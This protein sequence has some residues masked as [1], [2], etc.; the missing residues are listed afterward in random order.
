MGEWH[1]D[2]EAL[3]KFL[4]D[5]LTDADSRALQRHLFRC[6]ACEGQLIRLLP[7]VPGH[8]RNAVPEDLEAGY[9]SLIRELMDEMR[10]EMGD[11]KALLAREHREAQGL[12]REIRDLTS[13]QR[14]RRVKDHPRFHTWGLFELLLE[15]SR[16][17]TRVEP[18]RAEEQ[19]RLAL[20]L[21]DRLDPRRYGPGSVEA[22]KA[23][24]W[25]YLGN[26]LRILSHFRRAEQAF[27]MAELYL[28]QSWHDPLDEALILDLKGSLRR[29]QRRFDESLVLLDDAIG[30]YRELN[31]PHLQGRALMT[32]GL[33]L[34]YNGDVAG[35]T[36]CFRS[37]LFLLDGTEEPRLVAASQFNLMTCLYDSGLTVEAAALIPEARHLMEQVGT[38]SDLLHLRWL[39]AAVAAVLGQNE[40]AEQAFIEVKDAFSADR[41]A[42]DAALVSLDLASFYAR[43]GRT[44][45]VK[46]LAEEILP[47]FQSC[48]VPQEALAAV[49][50]FQKAAAME[51]LTLGLMDEI[52]AF[53][54]QVRSNPGL[55]FR[56]EAP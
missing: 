39:E 3:E 14:L 48:E 45:E 35:A 38:R 6:P 31:E 51:Q 16:H 32:K 5:R 43:Q 33:V 53:L 37:S 26:T 15:E 28:S 54:E 47:I 42:F 13:G 1:P 55:R 27:Q 56:G 22:A 20:A 44:A 46:P 18:L 19:L 29:A 4:D 30:L 11:R 50:V 2:R 40:E 41:L 23:R 21:T 9:G 10:P 49:I 7:A 8:S 34:Q 52:S 24:T 36:A 25:A 12:W 17:P